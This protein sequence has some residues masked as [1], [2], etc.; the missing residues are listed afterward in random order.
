[1]QLLG[2]REGMGAPSGGDEEGVHLR[3]DQQQPA[4]PP[5]ARQLANLSPSL[6]VVSTTWMT[7]FRFKPLSVVHRHKAAMA[8]IDLLHVLRG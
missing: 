3:A 6:P 5:L 1:M 2:A 4:Q 8:P 7:T